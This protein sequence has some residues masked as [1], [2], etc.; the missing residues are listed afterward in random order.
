MTKLVLEIDP[1]TKQPLIEV[2]ESI[3]SKLKPHQADGIRFMYTTCFE[4]V[5]QM[6]D[7][8]GGGC[9]LAHCMV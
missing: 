5:E 4:T 3:V 6:K 9:I 7:G 2:D 1:E 8:K